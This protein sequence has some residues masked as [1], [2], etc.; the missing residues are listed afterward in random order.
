MKVNTLEAAV[1]GDP[2]EPTIAAAT[3]VADFCDRS[4]ATSEQF[5][6]Q[7]TLHINTIVIVLN[8]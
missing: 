1:I 2:H 6:T 4:V 7:I 3:G 5:V 8:L